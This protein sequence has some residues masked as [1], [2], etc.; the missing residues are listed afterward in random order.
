MLDMSVDRCFALI[1]VCFVFSTHTFGAD[2]DSSSATKGE[3]WKNIASQQYRD[4]N[5]RI[6]ALNSML[7]EYHKGKIAKD[8]LL[9][10]LEDASRQSHFLRLQDLALEITIS[11]DREQGCR[12]LRR[13]ALDVASEPSYYALRSLLRNGCACVDVIEKF[14][15]SSPRIDARYSLMSV[16][17]GFRAKSSDERR[18]VFA[19]CLGLAEELKQLPVEHTMFQVMPL[20]AAVA[21]FVLSWWPNIETRVGGRKS[22]KTDR[23]Y[24]VSIWNY[25]AVN[26]AVL[27]QQLLDDIKVLFTQGEF[28]GR[29]AEQ[30][31]DG[32]FRGDWGLDRLYLLGDYA[33][34]YKKA[35]FAALG[36]CAPERDIILE[37]SRVF[38]VVFPTWDKLVQRAEEDRRKQPQDKD[39]SP[40][41]VGRV[42]PTGIVKG[43]IALLDALAQQGSH[44]VP[45]ERDL[46]GM[47]LFI[48]GLIER[49]PD[50]ETS[51]ELKELRE[52]IKTYRVIVKEISVKEAS[53]AQSSETQPSAR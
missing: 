31:L 18:R 52:K 49:Y 11:V 40:G 21:R 51:S 44:S 20:E 50:L 35:L 45:E 42:N 19:S 3:S 9:K 37:M 43:Q 5:E 7:A 34:E 17:A 39:P 46:R 47:E 26:A 36:T 24:W 6:S 48:K 27:D 12:E 29:K 1:I 4:E 38:K 41:V 13:V 33:S 15:K 53:A 22:F 23:E 10:R 32:L 8:D 16:L 30:M 2:V 28:D 25:S 14:L